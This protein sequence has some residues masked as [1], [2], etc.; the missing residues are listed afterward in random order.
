MRQMHRHP[1]RVSVQA[2]TDVCGSSVKNDQLG[3]CVIR[4]TDK[5]SVLRRSCFD[6]M[7]GHTGKPTVALAQF[8]CCFG[9]SA[10]L[11]DLDIH[12]PVW[13]WLGQN[14]EQGLVFIPYI[15]PPSW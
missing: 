7:R 5:L 13:G 3:S 1:V 15:L 14:V 6:S 4:S 10:Q 8:S 12:I 11:C 9:L 2:S